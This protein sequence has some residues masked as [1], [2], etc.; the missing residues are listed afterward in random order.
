MYEHLSK[1]KGTLCFYYVT[2]RRKDYILKAYLHLL[3][4][5]TNT[6]GITFNSRRLHRNSCRNKKQHSSPVD[7]GQI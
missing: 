6:M 2:P 3:I 1:E 5:Y 7:S 4:G